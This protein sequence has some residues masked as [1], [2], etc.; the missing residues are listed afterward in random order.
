MVIY[1]YNLCLYFICCRP[2]TTSIPSQYQQTT[3]RYY[4]CYLCVITYVSECVSKLMSNT[5]LL[6]YN[7]LVAASYKIDIH[8]NESDVYKPLAINHTPAASKHVSP[9]LP[10]SLKVCFI[11]YY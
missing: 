6:L 8:V 11:S 10:Y 1:S 4:Y 7:I 3:C 2:R 5:R 9:Q